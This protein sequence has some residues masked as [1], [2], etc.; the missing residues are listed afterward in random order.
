MPCSISDENRKLLLDILEEIVKDVPEI[1]P[2]IDALKKCEPCPQV[3]AMKIE[4]TAKPVSKPG[5]KLSAYQTFMSSC[6]KPMEKGGQGKGMKE[7]VVDWN[8]QKKPT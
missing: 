2:G 7:C 1:Q 5:R 6:M 3:S 8:A 4:G